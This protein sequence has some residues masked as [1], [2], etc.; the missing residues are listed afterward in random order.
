MTELFKNYFLALILTI[1]YSNSFLQS[2]ERRTLQTGFIFTDQ[3]KRTPDRGWLPSR[4][5]L[6]WSRI[7]HE[8]NPAN[9]HQI[10]ADCLA[11]DCFF[12]QELTMNEIQQRR[13]SKWRNHI[14]HNTWQEIF[15]KFSPVHHLKMNSYMYTTF[16]LPFCNPVH[17]NLYLHFQIYVCLRN[18]GD[19]P[20]R[21]WC[22]AE[23]LYWRTSHTNKYWWIHRKTESSTT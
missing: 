1:C 5:L 4:W 6:L 3:R 9:G 14:N 11:D 18:M 12:G 2:W 21:I 10:E 15:R 7:D 16:L 19:G 13:N 22:N 8:W 23:Y 20:E 17:L